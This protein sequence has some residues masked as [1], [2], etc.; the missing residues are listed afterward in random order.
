[1]LSSSSG[2]MSF[3]IYSFNK[4][5]IKMNFESINNKFKILDLSKK[6]SIISPRNLPK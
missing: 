4:S 2:I 6:M 3:K 5:S 1:M